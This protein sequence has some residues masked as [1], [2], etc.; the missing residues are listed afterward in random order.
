MPEVS[1]LMIAVGTGVVALSGWIVADIQRRKVNELEDIDAETFDWCAIRV[2]PKMME[3]IDEGA[4][5]LYRHK[6]FAPDR[7]YTQTSTNGEFSEEATKKFEEMSNEGW[8]RW[9][10]EEGETK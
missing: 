10:N 8:Y 6:R 7:L 1:G 5:L 4:T 3:A 9:E 2:H